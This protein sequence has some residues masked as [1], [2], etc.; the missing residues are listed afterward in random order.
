LTRKKK[1]AV[2]KGKTISLESFK[3]N[4]WGN[5][6]KIYKK[7]FDEEWD[8]IDTNWLKDAN[9]NIA[10]IKK[11]YPKENTQ[12]TY[13]SSFASISGVLGPSFKKAYTKY[14]EVSSSDRREKDVVDNDNAMTESEKEKMVSMRVLKNLCKHPDLTNRERALISL[15]TRIP[16][17]RNQLAQFLTLKKSEDGLVDG[18]N[19][20]IVN[21]ENN[22]QK[23]I[24]RKYKTFKQYGV[25]EIPLHGTDKLN[26]IL[27]RYIM[28]ADIKDGDLVF[29]NT[30]GKI[31]ADIS[32]EISDT[33]KKASGKPITVNIIRHIFISKFLEKKRSI[34][35]K[36]NLARLMG[37][38]RNV[39]EKYMR[40]DAPDGA[41]EDDKIKK[42]FY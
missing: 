1:Q 17:R 18:F 24:M 21:D 41:D 8:C 35:E 11:I 38:S 25:F 14:S 36:N 13:I 28:S 42:E 22:P 9:E 39:Q 20:L 19:Y 30:K 27:K 29:P 12:I 5:L 10:F 16:P 31:Q 23:I 33:F 40:V 15:Y 37:H 3:K 4:T 26:A 2:K 6:K 32:K 7:K 34:S